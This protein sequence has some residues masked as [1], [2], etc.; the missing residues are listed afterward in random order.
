MF[1]LHFNRSSTL[2]IKR[3]SKDSLTLKFPR[4]ESMCASYW[5]L[6]AIASS[7]S[8][9][10]V[11]V[12]HLNR[13]C[14]YSARTAATCRRRSCKIEASVTG[15]EHKQQVQKLN[16][17]I[18]AVQMAVKECWQ[19]WFSGGKEEWLSSRSIIGL[20]II[21]APKSPRTKSWVVRFLVLADT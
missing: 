16:S 6:V 14:S 5:C 15:W 17:W 3:L 9:L 1:F 11:L 10:L 20:M 19:S 18:S 2:P 7:N 4:T 8:R 13:A 12:R 21:V